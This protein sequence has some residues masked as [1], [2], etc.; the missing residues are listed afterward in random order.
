MTEG[1][2]EGIYRDMGTWGIWRHGIGVG[3]VRL[4]RSGGVV[5][6]FGREREIAEESL[7]FSR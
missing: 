5:V 6:P 3:M 1:R 2:G 4:D 7:V